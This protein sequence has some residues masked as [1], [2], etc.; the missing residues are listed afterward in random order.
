[1]PQRVGCC[2]FRKIER[3][4]QALHHELND[5]RRQ[6]ATVCAHEGWLLWRAFVG[7]D[8][9]IVGDELQHWDKN[10]NH[11]VLVTLSGDDDG[12]AAA[13]GRNVLDL[14]AESFRDAQARSVQQCQHCSVPR[15]YPGCLLFASAQAYIRKTLR[16]R[17]RQRLRQGPCDLGGPDGSQCTNLAVSLPFEET[18]EGARARQRSHQGSPG[19]AL[20]AAIRH[21]STY[22]LCSELAQTCKI[23]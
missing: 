5:A 23:H 13:R 22:I 8:R 15:Q 1:M 2:G 20:T 17:N 10:R 18:R 3:L 9:E 19:S 21:E 16:R 11:A 4:P 14:E 6:R 7:A 12:V